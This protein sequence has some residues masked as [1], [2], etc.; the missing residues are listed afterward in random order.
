MGGHFNAPIHRLYQQQHFN[1]IRPTY[2]PQIVLLSVWLLLSQYCNTIATNNAS[3]GK[4]NAIFYYQG[5]D[6]L[7]FVKITDNIWKITCW[8]VDHLIYIHKSILLDPENLDPLKYTCKI[9]ITG[10]KSLPL[11]LHEQIAAIGGQIMYINIS[12]KSVNLT[13]LP[14]Q[15]Q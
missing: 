4:K 11:T 3:T 9:K 6:T 7:L 13:S 15:Y 1:S 2:K 10:N 5:F 8:M 12:H 14:S